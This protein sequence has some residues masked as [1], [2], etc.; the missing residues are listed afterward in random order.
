MGR[1]LRQLLASPSFS[2]PAVLGLAL[3]IGATTA[4]FSIV[5]RTLLNPMGLTDV[6]SLVALWQTD[7]KRGHQHIEASYADYQEWRKQ[8]AL[9]SDV[10]L[11]SSV[12]LDFP[13]VIDGEPRQVDGTTVTGNF[14]RT[15]GARPAAGRLFTDDDDQPGAPLRFVISH[16][17]WSTMFGGDPSVI[18]RQLRTDDGSGTVVGVTS[19]DFDFPRDVDLFT[20]LR[21]AW[22][23]V[24]KQSRLGVFRTIARLASNVPRGTLPERLTVLNQQLASTLPPGTPVYAV[25]VVPILDEIFGAARR[26]MWLLFGAVFVVLLIACVN[27][28]NL[29]MARATARTRELGIRSAM[30]AD[31]G[32]LLRLLLGESAVL[33]GVAGLL[34][35]ALA[36]FG[37]AVLARLAPPELPQIAQVEID[38][39]VLLFGIAVC[40]LTV[41]LFGLAPAW[42]ASRSDANEALKSASRSA[43]ADRTHTRTRALLIGGEIALSAVL[44]TGAGLLLRSFGALASVDPGFSAERILT[45]RVTTNAGSQ[46]VRRNTYSEILQRVRALPGVESAGAVLLR[47]LSGLVGWDSTYVIEGQS[48]EEQRANPACNY[49]AI[50]PNYFRTMSIRLLS[51]RDFTE[52]DTHTSPGV[53]IVNESTARRHWP[54]DSAVGKHIRLGA[55]S[56]SPWLTV[57]GIVSDV[58]YRE[59]EAVRPDIYVPY[60]QRAQHR[61]DFV[62]KTYGSPASLGP[63]IRKAVFAVNR[64]QP[65][66]NL[67]TMES[68]VDQAI[69]RAR[70]VSMVL[71]ALA[72]CAVV[73]A[74]IGAYAVLSY[75]ITQRRNE[76]AIRMALGATPQ[77]IL[78]LVL[79]SGLRIAA[80]GLAC[81]L[82]VALTASHLLQALLYGIS[83]YD[84]IA[85]GGA[86]G[87]LACAAVLACLAPAIR[88]ARVEPAR[89]LADE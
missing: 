70:F 77:S 7:A 1:T 66:S 14:F 73:L 49:E 20:P 75:T 76:M 56:K 4:V 43:S 5:H 84:A 88:A 65:I 74:A 21:A 71:T 30:G 67:T 50:S 63:D 58:R 68:L 82:L 45:F 17:L 60:M 54:G 48:P 52:G 79:R 33:A 39:P 25:R 51:G 69:A 85:Y 22:P 24:E 55:D 72:I 2:V 11:A 53:A 35:L 62:V 86:A 61:T 16:R 78:S 31:R 40:G 29:L 6:E 87:V 89:A 28:A 34:G 15:V 3:A 19:A 23:T 46:E 83:T 18:G 9:F 64:S 32:R 47:P 36:S 27:V 38:L 44:L 26:A 13:I 41:L 12:N 42:T 81:G 10:A 57:V 80:A 59:W 8:T 37:T